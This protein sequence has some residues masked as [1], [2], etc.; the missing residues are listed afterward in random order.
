M[1]IASPCR[2][3]L[4]MS[5]GNIVNGH[6]LSSLINRL[7]FYWRLESVDAGQFSE[8]LVWTD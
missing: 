3:M 5:K 2:E 6:N 7:I 4:R 8:V 1:V